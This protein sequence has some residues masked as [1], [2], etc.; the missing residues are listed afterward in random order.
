[1]AD[2]KI[3]AKIKALLTLAEHPGTPEHERLA[4]A[5]K[6]AELMEK[7]AID[8]LMA[9]GIEERHTDKVTRRNY[10]YNGVY[11]KA[12]RQACCSLAAALDMRSLYMD[13][14]NDEVTILVYGFESDFG[15]FETLLASLTLQMNTAFKLWKKEHADG[16]ATMDSHDR[17]YSK[18][19]FLMGYGSGFSSRVRAGRNHAV[20][21]SGSGA[22]LVLV[23]R[24]SRV[25]E[26]VED[27]HPNLK[28]SR[29]LLVNGAYSHGRAAGQ[30]ANTGETT[31]GTRKAVK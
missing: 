31:I 25:D 17:Y 27:A 14:H 23:D 6:A 12:M 30:R 29:D 11:S 5:E 26:H 24:K 28:K 8:E 7:Y 21:E 3:A 22:E 1:M 18:R 15:K 16:W 9:R 10:V 20:Q 19:S 2:T 4:A 13:G